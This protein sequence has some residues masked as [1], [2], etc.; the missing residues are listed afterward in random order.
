MKSQ[1]DI[2]SALIA[3]AAPQIAIVFA[4]REPRLLGTL[5]ALPA[6][7]A[8]AKNTV[9]GLLLGQSLSANYISI[10]ECRGQPFVVAHG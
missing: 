9:D 1:A 10:A 7:A 8:A 4:G 6:S 5:E 2:V 3:D